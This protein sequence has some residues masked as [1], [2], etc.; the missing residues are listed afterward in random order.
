MADTLGYYPQ[1]R[2]NLEQQGKRAKELLKAARSGEP[3]ALAPPN[4]APSARI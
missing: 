2:L 4:D 1:F 3:E